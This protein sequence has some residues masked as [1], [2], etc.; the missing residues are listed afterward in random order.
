ML[1]HPRATQSS[2]TRSS[3]TLSWTQDTLEGVRFPPS[4]RRPGCS[5][6]E[7]GGG[8]REQMVR[9]SLLTPPNDP[10]QNHRRCPGS[11]VIA[12][13]LTP[14]DLGEHSS[15]S[16][17]TTYDIDVASDCLS[18]LK[19]NAW[20]APGLPYLWCYPLSIVCIHQNIWVSYRMKNKSANKVQTEEH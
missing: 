2:H 14:V 8:S 17:V 13:I 15:K 9:A 1:R 19:K 18:T 7:A 6:G 11:R 16:G 12:A 5:P 3:A 10:D 20:K 4:P